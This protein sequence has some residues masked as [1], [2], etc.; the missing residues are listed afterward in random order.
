MVLHFLPQVLLLL[1]PVHEQSAA[2]QESE[3]KQG[4]QNSTNHNTSKLSSCKTT[5]SCRVWDCARDASI[6]WGWCGGDSRRHTR[7]C[8]REQRLQTREDWQLDALTSCADIAF[9]ATRVCRV[10]CARATVSA[11]SFDVVLIAAVGRFVAEAGYAVASDGIGGKS[12]VGEV[13]AQ[14]RKGV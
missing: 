11:Q 8:C 5:R 7:C 14:L 4:S 10:H 2:D 9:E 3:Q 13:G 6:R 1:A 12:A